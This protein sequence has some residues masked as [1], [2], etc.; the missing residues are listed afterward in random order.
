[1]FSGIAWHFDLDSIPIC[2]GSLVLA[3]LLLLVHPTLCHAQK[4]RM[5]L[6][7]EIGQINALRR[8]AGGEPFVDT[9]VVPCRSDV[10]TFED[11]RKYIRLYFPRTY[12]AMRSFGFIILTAVEYNLLSPEQDRWMYNSIREGTGGINDNSVFSVIST[13]MTAWANSQTQQAFPNDAP[14]VAGRGGARASLLAFRV[15]IDR[16][17]RDPLLTI[18][19]PFGVEKAPCWGVSSVVIP[20][21]GAATLAWQYG[22][23]PSQEPY[24]AVW[25][26]EKGR[27]YTC[28]SLIP[29]GWFNYP[30]NPYCPEI[31]INMIF[32]STVRKL[33]ED[34][35]IFHMARS[36]VI[37]FNMR[38]GILLSLR[39][40]ID[41]FGA[42]TQAIEEQ[43]VELDRLYQ[44]GVQ[45]YIDLDF[46]RCQEHMSG[47]LDRFARAEKT[48]VEIKNLALFWVYL[49][50]WLVVSSV[51]C[52]S[53]FA[54]WTLMVRRQ[55]YR[56]TTTTMLARRVR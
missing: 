15:A 17:F 24:L 53:G 44:E 7:G 10:G 43:I 37:Q 45:Y 27:T 20:R 23:F 4:T 12:E 50:E 32:Y 55:L 42:K 22:H 25:D 18:F 31:L 8:L 3:I 51:L 46:L 41:A 1:M 6:V 16:D 29:G 14:A 19:L 13:I 2:R 33:I 52:I 39:D 36:S 48:A 5:L 47:V 21:E 38:R 40:F 56:Q 49:V 30:D 11:A 26:Y 34:V 28:G 9:V 35:Q 54:L